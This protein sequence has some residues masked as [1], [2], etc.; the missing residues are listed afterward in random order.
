[1]VANIPD[2]YKSIFTVTTHVY[3][4]QGE[5]EESK[6]SVVKDADGNV[7]ATSTV[8]VDKPDNPDDISTIEESAVQ[9]AVKTKNQKAVKEVLGDGNYG[10][11]SSCLNINQVR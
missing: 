2:S 8:K 7:L 4:D 5:F 6:P 10:P 3:T 11:M 9:I 1:M